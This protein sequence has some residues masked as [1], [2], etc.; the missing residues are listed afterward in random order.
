VVDALRRRRVADDVR[1]TLSAAG[2]REYPYD[3]P[4]SARRLAARRVSEEAREEVIARLAELE[5][6]S[7]EDVRAR[8]RAVGG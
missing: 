1:A 8:L 5:G 3:P 7:V 6:Q 2:H 4:A